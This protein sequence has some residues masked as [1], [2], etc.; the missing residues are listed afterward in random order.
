MISCTSPAPWP[1]RSTLSDISHL[2][3]PRLVNFRHLFLN[4]QI[5]AAPYYDGTTARIYPR[6]IG[7]D[8]LSS[9]HLVSTVAP[10]QGRNT[11]GA[12]GRLCREG[13]SN[14][15]CCTVRST[16]PTRSISLPTSFARSS[17]SAALSFAYAPSA[18]TGIVVL[19]PWEHLPVLQNKFSSKKPGPFTIITVRLTIQRDPRCKL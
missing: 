14:A 9:C 10:A 8:Y 12:I 4:Y 18:P 19:F 13:I 3:L 15:T 11:T 16:V 17:P 1:R 2:Y 7:R 5:V 6:R